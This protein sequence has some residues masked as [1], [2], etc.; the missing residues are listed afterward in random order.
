MQAYK[1]SHNNWELESNIE[2]ENGYTLRV[3]TCKR[4]SGELTTTATAVKQEDGF[5]THRMYQD[6]SSRVVVSR[7]GRITKG[8]VEKQ[9]AEAMANI[10]EVVAQANEKQ[11]LQN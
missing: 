2:L 6:Y 5:F 8:A 7:P 9:H 3:V 10:A 11:A 1:N 4:Y